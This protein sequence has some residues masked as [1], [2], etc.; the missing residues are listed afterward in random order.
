MLS[1]TGDKNAFILLMQVELI[2][3]Q[4]S[5]RLAYLQILLLNCIVN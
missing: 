1:Y 3:L 5:A 2:S 4:F